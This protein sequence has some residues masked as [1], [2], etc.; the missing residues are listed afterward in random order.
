MQTF[1]NQQILAVCYKSVCRCIY[2]WNRH[3][4]ICLQ[5]I[6]ILSLTWI[7]EL[8][9]VYQVS[10]K[11]SISELCALLTIG[12]FFGTPCRCLRCQDDDV[13]YSSIIN[14]FELFNNTL[15]TWAQFHYC[16]TNG[17]VHEEWVIIR[18]CNWSIYIKIK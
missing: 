11:M 7:S 1:R 17:H 5:V 18:I 2:L 16:V 3:I 10:Q 6:Y 8:I 12:H 14:S 4:E 13:G 15:I 9:L